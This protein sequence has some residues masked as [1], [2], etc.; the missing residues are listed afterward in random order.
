MSKLQEIHLSVPNLP[1]MNETQSDVMSQIINANEFE[2]ILELGTYQGKGTLCMAA[3]CEDRG[4][5]HVTTMDR[6]FT[7]TLKP[8]LTKLAKRFKL[9]KRITQIVGQVS[10][11][12]DL[13][14]LIKDNK[15]YDLCYIDTAHIFETTAL[16]F[17]LVDEMLG[18]GSIVIFDD[19]NWTPRLNDSGVFTD[20]SNPQY[21]ALLSDEELDTPAVNTVAD[22]VQSKDNYTEI[23]DQYPTMCPDFWRI[24]R[25]DM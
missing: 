7:N 4:A 23:S 9:N 10:Y 22:L 1:F 15:Q 13:N 18:A 2:S 21:M 3:I 19:V 14:K 6:A 17:Y 11:M 25:K 8:G 16:S 5:G 24:F 20:P 12:W